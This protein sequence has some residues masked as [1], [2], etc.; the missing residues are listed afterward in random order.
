MKKIKEKLKRI[1]AVITDKTT[2]TETTYTTYWINGVRFRVIKDFGTTSFKRVTAF[3]YATKNIDYGMIQ[4][5]IIFAMDLV[6]ESNANKKSNDV[7]ALAMAIKNNLDSYTPVR[8]LWEI[9]NTFILLD[10]EPENELSAE[11]SLKKK[12]LC[13]NSEEIELFFLM[14]AINILK[15]MNLLPTDTEI[16]DYSR[17]GI[18]RQREKQSLSAINKTIYS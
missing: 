18:Q 15:A 10:G 6:L 1:W 17:E 3:N 14:S 12:A 16:G 8:V 11:F 5:D 9:C 7:A 4:Q 13:E 2:V